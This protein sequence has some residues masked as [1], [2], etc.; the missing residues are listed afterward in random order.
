[1]NGQ[2]NNWVEKKYKA[3]QLSKVLWED[4]CV[5]LADS[6]QSFN[7]LYAGR[8]KFSRTNGHHFRI[9]E[10]NKSIVVDGDFDQEH[11]TI[12]T[13]W[14]A[15]NNAMGVVNFMIESDHERAFIVDAK[16]QRLTVEEASV[17]ILR[18]LF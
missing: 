5:A 14:H 10:E 18:N 12:A 3:E 16:S 9:E 17:S 6:C 4:L 2:P 1:M 11:S 13:T 7:K 8:S 15:P